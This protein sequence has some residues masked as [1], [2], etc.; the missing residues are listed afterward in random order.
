MSLGVPLN[1]A[2]V[3]V[4]ISLLL[5]MPAVARAEW[6]AV[7]QVRTYAINGTTGMEL[8]HS[9][10]ER[11]PEVRGS[12]AIAFTDFKLTWSRKYEPRNG[13]CVLASARPNLVITYMLP[14][15]AK[16]LPTPVRAKWETFFAGV[17][18][19]ER[20]HGD[21]IKDMVRQI[22]EVSVGLAVA[23][24]PDCRKIRKELTR[25]L[26][27][28]SQAKGKR[29]SDFDR[30]ELKSGGNVRQLVVDLVNDGLGPL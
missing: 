11:G 16:K 22:E 10:G 26:G 21:F 27:P 28:I 8:Y 20:V 24:D 13:G 2:V 3:R 5:S 12:R 6:Q 18:A 23:D 15:P 9:I 30:A 1:S 4:L 29:D 14:K 25:R 19:H 7:E 17:E